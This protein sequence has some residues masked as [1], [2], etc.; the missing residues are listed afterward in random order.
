VRKNGR[1]SYQLTSTISPEKKELSALGP[2]L[3]NILRRLVPTIVRL[4]EIPFLKA[5][6]SLK[7]AVVGLVFLTPSKKGAYSI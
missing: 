5:I 3:L 1:K 2:A 4:V 7:A 6:P